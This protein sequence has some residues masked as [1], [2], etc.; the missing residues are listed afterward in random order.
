M[1]VL[2]CLLIIKVDGQPL[3][4][5]NKIAQFF[6]WKVFFVLVVLLPVAGALSSDAVD[7]KTL[8]SSMATS[9]LSGLPSFLVIFAIVLLPAILTQFAN[10]MVVTSVFVTIICFMGSAL[11]FNQ[12]L[13]S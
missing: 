3:M 6:P 10:N 9:L 5:L 12:S 13:M 1:A 4:D 2:A 11:P 8:L 7:L